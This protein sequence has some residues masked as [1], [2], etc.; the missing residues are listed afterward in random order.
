MNGADDPGWRFALRALIPIVGLRY[1][2][3]RAPDGLTALRSVF[4]GLV[5]ALPLFLVSFSY[6]VEEP[7][8]V[9]LAPYAVVAVGLLS[10]LGISIL[11]RRTLPTESL[12]SL[13]AAWRARFFIG[14][15]F[16]E[17]P[18]LVGLAF[19][20]PTNALWIYLI[21]M[22]FSLI[23]FWRI[24]P[25]RTNLSRDQDALRSAGSSLD[26]TQALTATGPTPPERPPR[27][28]G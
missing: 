13:A 28:G 15:G 12:G 9:G 14:V 22:A 3:Q 8:P 4:V 10:T 11:H 2:A 24:A 20:L 19:T 23:G 26:L 21:G 7:G 1:R 17:V 27:A 18:A 25:S 6:I 16:T 5:T